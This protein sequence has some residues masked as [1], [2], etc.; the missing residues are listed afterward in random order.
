MRNGIFEINFFVYFPAKKWRM[1]PPASPKI[2]RMNIIHRGICSGQDKAVRVKMTIGPSSKS[3][4]ST[5]L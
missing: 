1:S 2:A 3:A 4:I 5:R